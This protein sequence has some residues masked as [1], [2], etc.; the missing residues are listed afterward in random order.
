M[1]KNI[2]FYGP[3]GTGKTFFMQKMMSDYI[4]YNIEDD[5]I[6]QTYMH[7]SEKWLLL[8]LILLQNGHLMDS[9]E[10]SRKVDTLH[11]LD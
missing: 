4:D 1:A 6:R 8:A 9:A 3:P 11:I 10:I 7:N 2:I 5:T